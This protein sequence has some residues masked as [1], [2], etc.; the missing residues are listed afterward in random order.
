MA[1]LEAALHDSPAPD[2]VIVSLGHLDLPGDGD[3]EADGLKRAFDSGVYALLDLAQFLH[4]SRSRARVV[5]V[6]PDSGSAESGATSLAAAP[7]LGFLRVAA[8]EMPEVVWQAVVWTPGTDPAS[9]EALAAECLRTDREPEV[10]LTGETRRVRRLRRVRGEDLPRLVRSTRRADGTFLPY[11]IECE[12]RGRLDRIALNEVRRREPGPGQVEIRVQAAGINF[13]DLMKVLGIYPGTPEELALL[14]DDYSGTVLRVGDAVTGVR[15]GDEVTG[16]FLGTFRSHLLADARL[17]FPK[18]A[19]FS[20]KE[21]ATLPTAFFT[22]HLALKET[23]RLRAGDSV[24]IHAAAGGVGLA[25]IQVA[26]AMGLTIYATAGSEEK[27]ALLRSLGVAHVMDSR[28]LSFAREVMEFTDGRGVDAV[29]NSLA[30]EFLRK[31][32]GVLAPFGRF[33]EIGKVDLFAD[34]ALGMRALRNSVSFHVIDLSQF[35]QL[36]PETARSLFAE[37]LEAFREGRYRPLPHTAFPPGEVSEA[38]HLMARG[39]HT[40]KLVLDFEPDDVLVGRP[41]EPGHGFSPDVTYLIAGGTS[42]YGFEVAKWLAKN[43]ARHLALMS[44]SGPADEVVREG[45]AGLEASGVR[46]RDVRADLADA[47]AVRTAVAEIEMEFPPVGGVFHTAMVLEN[48]FLHEL[49]R[50]SFAAALD[51]KALGAWNLHEATRHR[52]LD[53]FV[54]FSSFAAVVGAFRQANYNAGNTFLDELAAHRRSLGLPALSI[55]WGSLAGTGYVE[56]NRRTLAYLETTGVEAYGINEVLALLGQLLRTGATAL[57]AAKVDWSTLSRLAPAVADSPVFREVIGARGKGAGISRALLLSA[58]PGQRPRLVEDFL[59][60]Q[61]A[62]VF[63]AEEGSL[64]R[65]RSVTQLGLDSLMAIELLNRIEA[66]LGIHFP[67][68]S[69]LS[70]PS[71]QDLAAPVLEALVQSEA[72]G[73]ET[74][75]DESHGGTG[76]TPAA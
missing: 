4:R 60:A 20:W 31:S 59:A 32:L 47:T 16:L 44:R 3:L 62:A 66:E 53:C 51:P 73:A 67:V 12:R 27:R 68:G 41:T 30:G 45:I 69:L 39:G 43:G 6:L 48:R 2:P 35:L 40:G 18:P 10:A 55:S 58:D 9:L 52:A 75:P 54:L 26:Q 8:G 22:A 33:L 70:G 63:G 72:R 13:R 36:R 76:E 46:V 37:V 23:A 25:A 61:I 56:R 15:P 74:T 7:S 1:E 24:L 49:D 50:P 71:I 34:R 14:G 29:L 38:F 65:T 21:A 57:A 11:R 42:G 17:L 64:D 5:V 28:S 19:E